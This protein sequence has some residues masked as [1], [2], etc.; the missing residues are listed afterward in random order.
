MVFCW[1]VLCALQFAA[2]PEAFAGAYQL[3]GAAGAAAVRGMG[4][5]FLMWNATYPLFLW[6]PD[7]FKALGWIIVAQQV[8][9]LVGE[10][11]IFASLPNAGYE[12]LGASILR[13]AAFDGA[14][15]ILMMLSGAFFLFHTAKR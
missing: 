15:L 6:Q 8:I 14:G 5:A 12:M 4:V 9:G 7:R 2:A 1:N 10:C 11:A 3:E 13:F